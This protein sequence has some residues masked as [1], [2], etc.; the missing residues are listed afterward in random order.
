M[1]AIPACAADVTDGRRRYDGR[2]N[3]KFLTKKREFF[4]AFGSGRYSAEE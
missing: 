1:N 3:G 2:Q 4:T